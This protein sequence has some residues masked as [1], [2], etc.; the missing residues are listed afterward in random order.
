[1]FKNSNDFSLHIETI[2]QS[3]RINH[4][5]AVLH[6]CS[7]NMLEPD[8]VSSLISKSLKEKIASNMR[9]LNFLPRKATLEF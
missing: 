6:F 3:K 2:V 1:M 8:E 4:M 7:E 9:E 5:D